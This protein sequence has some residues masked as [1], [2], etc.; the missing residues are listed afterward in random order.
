MFEEFIWKNKFDMAYLP[1][2]QKKLCFEGEC[3]GNEFLNYG[4][5][6][7]LATIISTYGVI[8]GSTATV[9]GAM[10]IAPMMTP[11]MASTLAIVLGDTKRAGRSL[12]IVTISTV[13][14]ILL[15]VLLTCSISSLAIDFQENHEIISR[16]A[17]DMFALYV[18]L[19][20]G[21]AGAFVVS[22][23]SISDSLPG[24]AIAISLVPPLSVVGISLS[25]YHWGDATGS[26]LLF[27]TNLFA[28]LVSGGAVF[29]I[30]GINPGWMDKTRSKKRKQAFSIA[31]ICVALISVPLF[32]SGYETL[33]QAYNTKETQDIT[34]NWLS[35]SGYEITALDLRKQNLTLNIIGTGEMPDPELL[36]RA[37]DDHFKKPITIE[38]RV[39]PVNIIH[40][41]P[42]TRSYP[43]ITYFALQ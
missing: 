35:G 42:E 39:I 30:S 4:V 34:K 10:I 36:Y 6:L 17:P 28:I 38:M 26:F 29:W 12:M 31:V 5:L 2:L 9:I 33:G 27:L 18:A 20:S 21:A 14:V 43:P 22:R 37:L 32:I 40:Y 13:Y 15:A 23:E 1:V 25:K 16:T 41:S 19:A 8:A 24:V 3:A 11:I 7:T